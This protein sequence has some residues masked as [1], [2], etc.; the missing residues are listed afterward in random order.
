MSFPPSS[1]FA[2][3][4]LEETGRLGTAR[5]DTTTLAA[6]VAAAAVGAAVAAADGVQDERQQGGSEEDAGR[7]PNVGF[8]SRGENGAGTLVISRKGAATVTEGLQG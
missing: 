1:R 8:N 5:T 6:A 4:P 3:A 2:I 7:D